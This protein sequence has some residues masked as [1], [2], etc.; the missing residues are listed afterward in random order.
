MPVKSEYEVRSTAD[1]EQAPHH[2]LGSGISFPQPTLP[3]LGGHG[4]HRPAQSAVRGPGLFV[5]VGA[6]GERVPELPV[7]LPGAETGGGGEMEPSGSRQATG[8]ERLELIERNH[9]EPVI[10]IPRPRHRQ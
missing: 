1:P 3:A 2:E 6:T 10:A 4:A 7:L 5:R 9:L 8:I